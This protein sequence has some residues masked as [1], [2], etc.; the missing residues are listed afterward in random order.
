MRSRG[1]KLHRRDSFTRQM[2]HRCAGPKL[3]V[4]TIAVIVSLRGQRLE[5]DEIALF[6][7]ATFD[8]LCNQTTAIT[9][10]FQKLF[11]FSTEAGG[12]KTRIAVVLTAKTRFPNLKLTANEPLGTATPVSQPNLPITCFVNAGSRFYSDQR[13]RNCVATTCSYGAR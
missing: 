2:H 12:P 1:A 3:A 13:L 6:D 11:L 9:E 4:L 7:R 8:D 10:R 5:A